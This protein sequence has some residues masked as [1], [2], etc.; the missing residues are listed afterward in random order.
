MKD[1]CCGVVGPFP[2]VLRV[3]G[4]VPENHAVPVLPSVTLS[5]QEALL[6]PTGA[7]K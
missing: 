6:A 2:V 7:E 4:I 5:T 1:L 3:R